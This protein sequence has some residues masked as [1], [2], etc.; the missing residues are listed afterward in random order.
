[1]ST[2]QRSES[3]NTFFFK[4]VCKKTSLKEIVKQYKI[5][6][7]DQ[8]EKIVYADFNTWHNKPPIKSPSLFEKQMSMIYTYEVLKNFQVEI[9]GVLACFA[10]KVKEDGAIK[11]FKVQD[12]GKNKGFVAKRAC[13]SIV[14]FF[15]GIP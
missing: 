8:E 7:Q 2:T 14:V 6:L 5:A 4:Y 11:T 9:L 3:T 1:M 12:Y 10:L 13:L 15:V